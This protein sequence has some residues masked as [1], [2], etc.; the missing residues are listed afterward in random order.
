MEND[1]TRL[2][3]LVGSKID[4]TVVCE[5]MIDKDE[6]VIVSKT[7]SR[8]HLD[9]YGWLTAWNV[10]YNLPNSDTYSLWVD[11]NDIIVYISCL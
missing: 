1:L 5:A 9:E 4:E 10:Y 6:E 11:S 8:T 2:V 7:R 3:S